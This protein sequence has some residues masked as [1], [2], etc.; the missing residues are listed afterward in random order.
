MRGYTQIGV[1]GIQSWTT[2]KVLAFYN[3]YQSISVTLMKR[4]ANQLLERM[5]ETNQRAGVFKATGTEC[6]NANLKLPF[7][8]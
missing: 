6:C 3:F 7:N 8:D 4:H 1:A 2:D 5:I